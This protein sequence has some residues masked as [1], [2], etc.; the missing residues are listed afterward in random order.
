MIVVQAVS[1]ARQV[2]LNWFSMSANASCLAVVATS[3]LIYF[4]CGRKS[5]AWLRIALGCGM[6]LLVSVISNGY[7]FAATQVLPSLRRLVHHPT[8]RLEEGP[9]GHPQL[10]LVAG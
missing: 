10:R 9:R 3:T 2:G 7:V 8:L 5:C 6:S 4:R 1:R